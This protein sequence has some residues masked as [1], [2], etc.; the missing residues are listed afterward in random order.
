MAEC[1]GDQSQIEDI[2][3]DDC[4]GVGEDFTDSYT[5]TSGYIYVLRK[6]DHTGCPAKY[7][8]I[9]VQPEKYAKT[10]GSRLQQLIEVPVTN[11]CKAERDLRE[12][13][14]YAYHKS[15]EPGWF[16]ADSPEEVKSKCLEEL[17]KWSNTE[18]E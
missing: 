10:R 15:T 14:E 13:F 6:V 11:M 8:R 16:I 3:C 7:Y 12:V 5:H 9:E 1:E 17:K 2:K 18:A 4:D